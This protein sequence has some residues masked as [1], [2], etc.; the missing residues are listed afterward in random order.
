MYQRRI[1]EILEFSSWLLDLSRDNHGVA[2]ALG[3]LDAHAKSRDAGE[4]VCERDDTHDAI[5]VVN[6]PYPMHRAHVH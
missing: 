5:R 3:V 2:R 1:K 6:D 4:H